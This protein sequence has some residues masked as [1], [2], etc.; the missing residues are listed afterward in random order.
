LA[1]LVWPFAKRQAQQTLETENNGLKD[2]CEQKA[3]G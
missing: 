3:A 2:F 1:F